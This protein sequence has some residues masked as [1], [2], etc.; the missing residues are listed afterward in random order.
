MIQDISSRTYIAQSCVSCLSAVWTAVWALPGWYVHFITYLFQQCF[1]ESCSANF[2][3]HVIVYA[4]KDAAMFMMHMDHRHEFCHPQ[5]AVNFSALVILQL[6]HLSKFHHSSHEFDYSHCTCA[7]W[8]TK[9]MS[10]L[11]SLWTVLHPATCLITKAIEIP[12][13]HTILCM[14]NKPFGAESLKG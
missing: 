9:T 1:P 10:V 11:C 5:H 12:S 2:P 4:I 7:T 3:P 6:N 14:H 8:K 13:W